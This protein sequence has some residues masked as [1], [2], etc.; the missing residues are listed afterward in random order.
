MGR[1]RSRHRPLTTDL[2]IKIRDDPPFL[3]SRDFQPIGWNRIEISL[4]FCAMSMNSIFLDIDADILMILGDNPRDEI[5]SW[6]IPATA[7]ISWSLR[8]L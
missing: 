5:V 3:W 1:P 4:P 8:S 7:E 6:V 2:R